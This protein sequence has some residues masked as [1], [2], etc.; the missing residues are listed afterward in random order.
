MLVHL[1][2][3]YDKQWDSEQLCDVSEA[4]AL[5]DNRCTL[6]STLVP[7][8]DEESEQRNSEQVRDLSEAAAVTDAGGSSIRSGVLEFDAYCEQRRSATDLSVLS[9]DSSCDDISVFV[10]CVAKCAV[11]STECSC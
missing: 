6:V 4:V 10:R 1:N 5:T 2:D 3:E 8:H 7:G 9:R 11:C